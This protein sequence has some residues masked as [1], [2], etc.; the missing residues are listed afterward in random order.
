MGTSLVRP[1]DKQHHHLC[2][3]D[4]RVCVVLRCTV[5]PVH[6]RERDNRPEIKRIPSLPPLFQITEIPC[7]KSLAN[8]SFPPS[9]ALSAEKKITT[10]RYVMSSNTTRALSR[11][12]YT[13]EEEEELG[14]PFLLLRRA[15]SERLLRP[16]TE[17]REREPLKRKMWTE[18]CSAAFSQMI[19]A[20][21]GG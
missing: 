20:T 14:G 16:L 1:A 19:G 10:S 5:I 17:K 9:C 11:W 12:R 8:K 15:A 18:M 2:T 3:C 21:R 7:P 4:V 6:A 13:L